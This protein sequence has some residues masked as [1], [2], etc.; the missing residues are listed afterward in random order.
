MVTRRTMLLGTAIGGGVLLA[1]GVGVTA[2]YAAAIDAA[3][4][5]VSTATGTVATSFGALEYAD[6][7][8]GTPLL[9][10][11]GT[12]GGYDQ[13]LGF[14]APMIASG[15]R[16]ISPSRFGYL[17][18]DFPPDPSS[19]NQA[20]ALVELLDH[21]GI[22]KLAVAGGS[23]G[24]LPAIAFAIRHPDRCKALIAIVPASYVPGRPHTP[25]PTGFAETAMT[26]MLHSD[27]L[28]W[29]ALGTARDLMIG[30]LLATDPA[31]IAAASPAE[32]ARVH[33]ILWNI[34]P[35]SR[36]ANGLL[37]DAALASNPAPMDFAKITV[38]TLAISLE[39]D[40]FGTAA[41]ARYLTSVVPGSKLVLYPT[42]GHI[43]AGH[44]EE[45]F[46]EVAR[47]VDGLPA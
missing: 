33:D 8:T 16:I 7:G 40:R 32:Q 29:A 35:V 28:F 13:G 11:H 3:K 10:V 5:R 4:R 43:W 23:A 12:G 14:A 37:N 2:A 24:A 39:D 17:G 20:D 41:A 6:V 15:Y 18:S 45:L 22:D 34:L 27:F 38:P 1:G 46:G 9:M 25:G 36:R 26:A 19:D 30:T 31:I 47:F 42:G 21:L 44:N